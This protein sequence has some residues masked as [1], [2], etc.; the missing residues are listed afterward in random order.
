MPQATLGPTLERDERPSRPLTRYEDDV[1]A[2][3][4]EQAE[5]IRLGRFHDLDLIHLADE[6]DEE[7]ADVGR[8]EY[9]ELESDLACVMQH[10]LEWDRQP[11]R[12]SR[13]WVASIREHRRRVLRHLAETPSLKARQAEALEEACARGRGDASFETGL[14]DS[15]IPDADPYDW[16]E[17]MTRPVAWPEP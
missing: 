9:D 13:S 16:D 12:R 8:R 3:A 6:V 17:V 15:A 11:E 14:P 7:V 1:H 10:L 2:W 4:L 5:L